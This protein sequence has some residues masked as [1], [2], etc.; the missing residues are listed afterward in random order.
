MSID[1]LNK[2]AR[3]RTDKNRNR[4]TEATTFR[5]PYKHFLLLPSVINLAAGK[6]FSLAIPQDIE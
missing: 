6:F 4:W 3:L 5:A 1:Y 2:L